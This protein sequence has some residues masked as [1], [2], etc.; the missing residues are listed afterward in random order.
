M[1]TFS[2]RFNGILDFTLQGERV[3]KTYFELCVSTCQLQVAR[4]DIRMENA[5]RF[6]TFVL[7]WR[8]DVDTIGGFA[9]TF[10]ICGGSRNL[11]FS[12]G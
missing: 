2:A 5:P 10:G 12:Q 8:V 9:L 3:L 6:C 1:R 7:Q 11:P 4:R